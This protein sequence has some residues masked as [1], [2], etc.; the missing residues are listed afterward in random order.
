MTLPGLVSHKLCLVY[1]DQANLLPACMLTFACKRSDQLG[2][3]KLGTIKLGMVKA[4]EPLNP[5][6]CRYLRKCPQCGGF[7]PWVSWK[8]FLTSTAA[9]GNGGEAQIVVLYRSARRNHLRTAASWPS[10]L[11]C[12]PHG[13]RWREAGYVCLCPRLLPIVLALWEELLHKRATCSGALSLAS[14][15][16]CSAVRGTCPHVDYV[17]LYTW[18]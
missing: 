6:A 15:P 7:F 13:Q 17:S 11:A 5:S 2:L 8:L 16:P 9:P 10:S 14:I 3:I 12:M 1:W 4:L 18:Y